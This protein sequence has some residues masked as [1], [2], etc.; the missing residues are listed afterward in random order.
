MHDFC[1]E[2]TFMRE[3]TPLIKMNPIN[4]RYRYDNT[5]AVNSFLYMTH[6][7]RKLIVQFGFSS[8]VVYIFRKWK[9]GTCSC[10]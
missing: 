6:G 10:E 8:V 3:I 5:L 7:R 4:H 9:E 2:L 1:V